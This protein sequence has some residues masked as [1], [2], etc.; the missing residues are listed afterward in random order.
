[1]QLITQH[2]FDY[3]T[4]FAGDTAT[5]TVELEYKVNHDITIDVVAKFEETC[6]YYMPATEINPNESTGKIEFT[7][8]DQLELWEHGAINN[9]LLT[10]EVE[11][12]LESEL[13]KLNEEW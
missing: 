1:M 8:I 11:K 12:Q 5:H 9:T 3:Q 4:T 10:R 13:K 6:T 7:G 2:Q